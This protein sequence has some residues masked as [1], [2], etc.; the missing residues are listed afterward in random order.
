M[1]DEDIESFRSDKS[2]T[3]FTE[4]ESDRRSDNSRCDVDANEK[5]EDLNVIKFLDDG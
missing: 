1:T 5:D 2:W 4:E 3:T